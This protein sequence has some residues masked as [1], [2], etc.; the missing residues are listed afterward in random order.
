VAAGMPGA[1]AQTR[2]LDLREVEA[3]PFAFRRQ[4]GVAVAGELVGEPPSRGTRCD[5]G[6]V[7]RVRD[8][9]LGRCR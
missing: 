2:L 9:I 1:V 6:R 4:A 8:S 7:G 3:A 5:R